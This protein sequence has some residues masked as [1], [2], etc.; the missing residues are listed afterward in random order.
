MLNSCT[1]KQENKSSVPK[2]INKVIELDSNKQSLINTSDK[3]I[4]VVLDKMRGKKHL[5]DFDYQIICE[6]LQNNNDE[7]LAEEVG[8]TFYEFFKLNVAENSKFKDYIYELKNKKQILIAL[9][10]IMCLDLGEDNYNR[11][12]L[13]KDYPIF[14]GEIEALQSFEQCISVE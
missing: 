1:N 2:V 10:Q 14:N 8:Y 13:Q 3:N 5:T 12:K 4:A 7:A 9:V 6:F 11:Q